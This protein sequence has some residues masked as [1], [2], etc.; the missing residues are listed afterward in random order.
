MTIKK[1][2]ANKT[3]GPATK[4]SRKWMQHIVNEHPEVINQLLGVELE[5]ISPLK[6]ENYQEYQLRSPIVVDKI[7][8]TNKLKADFHNDFWPSKGRN[9]EWDGIA[10][11]NDTL[12]LF[13]AK[14][15]KSEVKGSNNVTNVLIKRTLKKTYEICLA[16]NAE[17][18]ASAWE[19]LYYQYANR[20]AFL[21]HFKENI[22]RNQ[23]PIKKVVMVFLDFVNDKMGKD[24]P[25]NKEEW[26]KYYETIHKE[27][28]V[29]TKKLESFGVKH[30]HIDVEKFQ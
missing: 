25:T 2:M 20:L 22:E 3:V 11:S 15:H 28:N 16:S 19:K 29:D 4:G 30:L 8:K 5:W 7:W 21:C 18:N 24:S 9:P 27:L 26:M 10:M 6:E 17:M 12:Y 13:E 14:S 23:L 1:Q